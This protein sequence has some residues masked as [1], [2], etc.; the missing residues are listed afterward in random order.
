MRNIADGNLREEEQHDGM[1]VHLVKVLCRWFVP[2]G[3][4]SMATF[5][6][7][8]HAQGT[9]HMGANCDVAVVAPQFAM[10]AALGLMEMDAVY[11]FTASTPL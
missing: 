1:E 6:L 4:V 2:T 5:L 11:I 9:V 7:L 10:I 3:M 8:Q